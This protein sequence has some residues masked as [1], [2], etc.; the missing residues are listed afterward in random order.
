ML[1][2]II[3]AVQV[4]VLLACLALA[5]YT[6]GPAERL[7]AIWWGA[8]WAAATL[9]IFL[10]LNSPTLQLILDGICATG[11]LPLAFIYVNWL[12]GAVALLQAATFTLEAAYLLE[13][14]KI[15]RF[16]VV[17]NDGITLAIAL[18]FLAAGLANLKHA[19]KPRLPARKTALSTAQA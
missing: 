19:Q 5:Y 9:L 1:W 2:F 14:Q 13:D 16:Y 6:G 18:M 3:F 11:F 7:A 12:A 17:V 15:D 4:I 10:N 8:N